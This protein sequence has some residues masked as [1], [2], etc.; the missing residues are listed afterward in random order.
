MK[1]WLWVIGRSQEQEC[2][3]GEIQNAVHLRRCHLIGDGK[4]RTIEEVMTGS[5]WCEDLANFLGI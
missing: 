5:A 3:C 4:G 2:Q 1:R